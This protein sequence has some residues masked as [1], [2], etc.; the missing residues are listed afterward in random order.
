[1]CQQHEVDPLQ[2]EV[3]R[4]PILDIGVPPAL[5]QAAIHKK[6]SLRVINA[7]T[8]TGHLT[9]RTEKTEFHRAHLPVSNDAPLKQAH[10]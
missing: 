9:C 4:L 8:G 7:Q 2:I 1:M 10:V 5:E 3:E 6:G